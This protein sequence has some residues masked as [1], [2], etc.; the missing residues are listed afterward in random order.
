MGIIMNEDK[1]IDDK[2]L[3]LIADS[4]EDNKQV[5]VLSCYTQDNNIYGIFINSLNNYLSFVKQP[6]S[7]ITMEIDGHQVVFI[8]LGAIL[9]YIYNIGSPSFYNFL[10]NATSDNE[11][12][13]DIISFVINNPPIEKFIGQLQ[14]MILS[15]RTNDFQYKEI[16][17]TLVEI[18]SFDKIYKI[19]DDEMNLLQDDDNYIIKLQVYIDNIMNKLEII[20]V[21]KISEKKISEL[22]IMFTKL[23]LNIGIYGI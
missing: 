12:F 17:N 22:D 3:R 10:I 19:I 7:D 14:N 9:Y 15:L 21:S 2:T 11:E 6:E 23:C 5:I 4:F 8:E 18:K 1:P 13:N 16:E 20:R